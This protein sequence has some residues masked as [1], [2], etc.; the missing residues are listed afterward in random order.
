MHHGVESRLPCL[1][2]LLRKWISVNQ[3]LG[4]EWST[5]GDAPWWYNERA[6]LSVLAGA[7]W[8]CGDSAFEEYSESK[9]T[10]ASMSTGRIDLWFSAGKQ[11]FGA[12]AKMCQI[13]ITENAGQVNG[14]RACMEKAKADVRR[15]SVH[16]YPRRLAI[17]FGA[18]YLRP[19]CKDHLKS[20]TE[21]LVTQA[22]K[23]P[24]DGMAW[25]FPELKEPPEINNWI[26]PG[27]IIWI[28]EVKR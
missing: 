25:V 2:P 20:R 17:V 8:L 15:C 11:E 3:R 7:V 12:E 24:H 14:M 13:P 18:P 1:K 28:K 9:K 4:R 6:L 23:V 21:W 22:M 19:C 26:H 5:T 27:A 16:D 10:R